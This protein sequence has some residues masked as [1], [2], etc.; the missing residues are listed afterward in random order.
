MRAILFLKKILSILRRSMKYMKFFVLIS[1]FLLFIPFF[2]RYT[3]IG[4]DLIVC[5]HFGIADLGI[6]VLTLI[7]PNT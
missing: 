5:D 4:N 2:I 1:N 3:Y 6:T 7:L